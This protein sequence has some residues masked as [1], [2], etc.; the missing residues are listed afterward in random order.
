MGTRK[1]NIDIQTR[2]SRALHLRQTGASLEAVATVIAEEFKIA[3]YDRRRA[4]EDIDECLKKLNEEC[5]H[6]TEQYRRQQLERLDEYLFRLQPA[7]NAGDVKAIGTAIQIIDR[8]CKLLGLDAPIQLMV[9]QQAEREIEAEL[10]SFL[11]SVQGLLSRDAYRELMDA[12]VVIGER[13][14]NAE[15]N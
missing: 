8:K 5:S 12:V 15:E 2:R 10:R 11:T 1:K 4:F 14:A 6:T 3:S 9:Q 7:I 13:S